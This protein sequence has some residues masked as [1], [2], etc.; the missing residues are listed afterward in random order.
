MAKNIYPATP[1]QFSTTDTQP[2]G[3]GI[4]MVK[5]DFSLSL[6]DLVVRQGVVVGRLQLAGVF[7]LLLW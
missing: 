7:A 2:L 6:A 1:K 3:L 4:R 5:A